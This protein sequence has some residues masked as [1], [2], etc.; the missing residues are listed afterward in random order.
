MENKLLKLFLLVVVFFWAPLISCDKGPYSP[1]V[2]GE[3]EYSGAG[4]ARNFS[5]GTET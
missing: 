1:E 3:D 4:Y 5:Q 2:L